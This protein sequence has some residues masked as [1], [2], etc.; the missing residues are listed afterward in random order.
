MILYNFDRIFE[1]GL[2]L[3]IGTIYQISELSLMR[4]GTMPEHTQVCDEIT[5]V[6]SGK[7]K[8]IS[9]DCCEDIS[10]GQIHF[11]K[12]G[13]VHKFEVYPDDDFRYIC[14]GYTTDKKEKF[15]EDF[16]NLVKLKKYF[17]TDD[18]STVKKLS[19]LMVDESY[20]WDE[21]SETMISQY[22]SQIVVN[23]SSILSGKSKRLTAKNNEISMAS[24]TIYKILRFVDRE[25]LNIE[26]VKDISESL[27]YSEYYISH[28][29]SEKMGVTVK[30]YITRKKVSHACELLKTSPLGI[31]EISEHL[32]FSSSHSFRR[33]FKKITGVS[34]REYKNKKPQ[35]LYH[36]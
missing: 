8:V 2:E 6:L 13:S 21:Y 9:D 22:L 30:E 5:Y 17:V 29:F 16:Y 24:S 3:P 33:A 32:N 11:V 1:E 4:G 36:N 20:D 31:E 25:Y 18:D 35:I 34:P 15:M 23:L 19:S 10:A 12:K 7:A 27:S 14:I 28:L 26:S